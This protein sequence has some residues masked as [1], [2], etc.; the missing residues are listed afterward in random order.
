MTKKSRSKYILCTPWDEP[1]EIDIYNWK[2]GGLF[3]NYW[4]RSFQEFERISPISGLIFYVV[5]NHMLVCDLPSY[6]DNVVAFIVTDEECVVPRY[7]PKVRFVFKTYGFQPWC[8]DSLPSP[9]S[10][11]KCARDWA[12]WALEREARIGLVLDAAEKPD[13]VAARFERLTRHI[14]LLRVPQRDHLLGALRERRSVA[15]HK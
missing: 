2:G 10:A 5:W 15:P 3:I 4:V 14:R 13:E 9:A 6:G 1:T 7:L 11:L 8:S 12:V